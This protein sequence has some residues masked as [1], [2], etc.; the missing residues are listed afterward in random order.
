MSG[1]SRASIS[2]YIIFS[3]ALA[4]ASASALAQGQ[5][6]TPIDMAKEH[7]D[8]L[9]SHQAFLEQMYLS[10]AVVIGVV[11]TVFGGLVVFFGLRSKA[12]IDEMVRDH[13]ASRINKR[14]EQLFDDLQ[15]E[16]AANFHERVQEAAEQVS[17]DLAGSNQ[18]IAEIEQ[19]V[20]ELRA[21]LGAKAKEDP[22]GASWKGDP[23][24]SQE[25][26]R[27]PDEIAWERMKYALL[28]HKYVWRSIERLAL[29]ARISPLEAEEILGKH[30]KEVRVSRGKSGRRIARHL[31]RQPTR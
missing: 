16:M 10:A 24:E 23:A 12:Q 22:A 5:A 26:G 9:R 1:R 25:A 18:A 8:L 13:F 30:S 2:L 14:V 28:N 17:D 29:E 20:A 27:D 15:E 6:D 31:T 4:A 7:L 3:I 21:K 19:D 11:A